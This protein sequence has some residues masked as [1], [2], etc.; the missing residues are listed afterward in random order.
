MAKATSLKILEFNMR[1]EM[2]K[3]YPLMLGIHLSPEQIE[4]LRSYNWNDVT[5]TNFYPA[6]TF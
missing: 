3:I 1:S 6:F 5:E 4:V 2:L